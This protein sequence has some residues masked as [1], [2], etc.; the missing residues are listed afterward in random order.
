VPNDP[1]LWQPDR[2]D[3]FCAARRALIA[4]GLNDMLGLSVDGDVEE[5]LAADES[6]EPELGA[7]AED[8]LLDVEVA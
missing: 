4:D 2:F 5:P 7:W 8:N 3:E 1:A 6:P